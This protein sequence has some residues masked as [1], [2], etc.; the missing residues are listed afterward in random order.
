MQKNLVD[1]FFMELAKGVDR[2]A[3]IILTGAAAGEIYGNIRPS[4]DID[5]EICLDEKNETYLFYLENL[6]KDISARIGIETDYSED[7]S[8]WSMINLLDYRQKAVPYKKIGKLNI[9]ILAPEH[10]TIG[11]ITRFYDLDIRDVLVV[12]QKKK[13]DADELIELWARAFKASPLS[14]AK[15]QFIDHVREFLKIYGKKAWGNSFK[16]EKMV[17]KFENLIYKVSML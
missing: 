3:S 5:F 11:K 2:P 14:L 8:H 1:L 4:M 6:I 16:S 9:R 7:I 10:W 17:K 15:R 12:I 13:L